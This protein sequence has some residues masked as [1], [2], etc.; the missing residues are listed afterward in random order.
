MIL[1]WSARELHCLKPKARAYQGSSIVGIIEFLSFSDDKPWDF[2]LDETSP[3]IVP[4]ATWG[5][6]RDLL[7][8]S[9]YCQW[10]YALGY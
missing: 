7:W 6:T 5:R 3:H 4:A 9:K 10:F 8:N 2:S 1:H